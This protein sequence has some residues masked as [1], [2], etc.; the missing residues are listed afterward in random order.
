MFTRLRHSNRI[1][2]ALPRFL[3]LGSLVLASSLLFSSPAA[4]DD[5]HD[6]CPASRN[7]FVGP[8]HLDD[9]TGAWYSTLTSN[10][11]FDSLRTHRFLN[12]CTVEEII[13]APASDASVQQRVLQG[14]P[15]GYTTVTRDRDELF[16]FYGTSPDPSA[17]TDE[18]ELAGLC[19]FGPSTAKIDA[20]TLTVIWRKLLYNAKASNAWNYAGGVGVHANGFIYTITDSLAFKQ[21]PATGEILATTQLPTPDTNGQTPLD[22]V[23]NG[24]IVLGDGKL[25]TK[26]VTRK[27]G[28]TLLG[29]QALVGCPDLSIPAQ[30]TVLDPD[31]LQILS[32]IAAPQAALGRITSAVFEGQ[33][34]VYLAGASANDPNAE[35]P[36]DYRPSRTY[37]LSVSQKD[38]CALRS[39]P[40]SRRSPTSASSGRNREPRSESWAT[41]RLFRPISLSKRN[42]TL[43]LLCSRNPM[44]A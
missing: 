18:G 12:T 36:M 30:I 6:R 14:F 41:T 11:A 13:K 31:T 17:C 38:Q 15:D 25:I 35:E 33:E 21:D 2:F 42:T 16:V 44:A 4:A 34:Y 3:L 10:E 28:C 27:A 40:T 5:G 23:Y 39:T 20:N 32:T 8:G 1:R 26:Q 9:P 43:G 24:F 7:M 22:T 37:R 29:L 19:A